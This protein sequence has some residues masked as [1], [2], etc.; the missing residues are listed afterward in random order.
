MAYLNISDELK[1]AL[2][3]LDL[4]LEQE[5]LSLALL[6]VGANGMRCQGL[7]GRGIQLCLSTV[8]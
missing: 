3:A 2:A 8:Q 6:L 5:R 7:I 4:F 1:R